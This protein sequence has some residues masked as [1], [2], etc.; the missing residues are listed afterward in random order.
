VRAFTISAAL[1]ATLFAAACSKPKAPASDV[2]ASTPTSTVQASEPASTSAQVASADAG[3]TGGSSGG[4]SSGCNSTPS[5]PTTTCTY[6]PNGSGG[7]T[8]NCM[9]VGPLQAPCIQAAPVARPAA[10]AVAAVPA[11]VAV[12][13][14]AAAD[15]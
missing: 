13:A 15:H 11:P 1:V 14:A 4:S 3:S 9:T 5:P 10:A 6:V 8:Q 7:M 2:Q 12:P